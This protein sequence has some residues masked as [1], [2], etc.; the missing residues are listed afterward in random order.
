MELNYLSDMLVELKDDE[1]FDIEGAGTNNTSSAIT[2]IGTTAI[3]TAGTIVFY[4]AVCNAIFQEKDV[5]YAGGDASTGTPTCPTC[6]DYLSAEEVPE[7]T[8]PGC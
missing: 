2:I 4:C 8:H 3:L 7:D 5:V 1:L 6:G